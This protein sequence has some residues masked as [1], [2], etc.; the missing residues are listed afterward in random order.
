[1]SFSR[2]ELCFTNSALN[3]GYAV[4]RATVVRAVCVSGLLAFLGIKHA[5]AYNQF[6]LCDDLIEPF[7][8]LVDRCVLGLLKGDEFLQKQHKRALIENLQ[9]SVLINEK[10]LPLIRGVNHFVQSF[11]NALLNGGELAN[12]SLA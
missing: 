10:K 2:D 1:M 9:S 4:V 11:K 12:V 7:R 6:N 3:Y 5:N 8:P